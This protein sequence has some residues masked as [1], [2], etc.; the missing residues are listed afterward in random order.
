MGNPH[1]AP[2]ITAQEDIS[3]IPN[4]VL[5]MGLKILPKKSPT[6]EYMISSDTIINGKSEGITVLVQSISP[7][8]IC[9]MAM[10]EK[11]IVKIRHVPHIT[12]NA[13]RFNGGLWDAVIIVLPPA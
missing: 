5:V 4:K 11:Q 8:R 7:D 2:K 9:S 1:S 10:S 6:L 12:A 13:I 3:D